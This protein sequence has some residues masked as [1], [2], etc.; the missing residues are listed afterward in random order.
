MG[1]QCLSA[2]GGLAGEIL[3]VCCRAATAAAAWPAA[4]QRAC[5]EPID[6]SACASWPS[7]PSGSS[8]H[9]CGSL[10]QPWPSVL[11]CAGA[12]S[13][14]HQH[15]PPSGA[16]A[17]PTEEAGL[18]RALLLLCVPPQGRQAHLRSQG[19]WLCGGCLFYKV[20]RCTRRGAVGA[21]CQ[22]WV[23]RARSA[24]VISQKVGSLQSAR[25]VLSWTRSI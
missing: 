25:R 4:P 14:L 2:G 23:L 11:Q 3:R 13:R 21:V 19:D 12:G 24:L 17:L 9:G 6:A 10:G 16:A 22:A 20:A 1:Q 7:S 5:S 15:A 8:G 18:A